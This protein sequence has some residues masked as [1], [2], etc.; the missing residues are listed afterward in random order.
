MFNVLQK[1][2]FYD[3]NCCITTNQPEVGLYP[4]APGGAD[5]G[6]HGAVGDGKGTTTSSDTTGHP[7]GR[8]REEHAI[9]M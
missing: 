3:P 5:G 2:V 7:G 6:S 1:P 8:K 9:H 4:P